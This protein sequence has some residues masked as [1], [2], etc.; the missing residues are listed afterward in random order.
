MKHNELR[1]DPPKW[2][3]RYWVYYVFSAVFLTVVSAIGVLGP[4]YCVGY[5]VYRYLVNELSLA[6]TVFASLLL[7]LTLEVGMCWISATAHTALAGQRFSYLFTEDG[8]TVI[9]PILSIPNRQFTILWSEIEKVTLIYRAD[10]D[11]KPDT[12][13]F[14]KKGT[15][16][17]IYGKLPVL[18]PLYYRQII[19][20]SYSTE[21]DEY[22][23]QN[24]TKT[25]SERTWTY[26]KMYY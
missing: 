16:K 9:R 10:E 25:I 22:L 17:N 14:I 21:L 23:K 20:I 15:K 6:R 11:H 26:D 4:L 12:Y 24:Y 2:S 13:V 19:I 18:N 1:I 3:V 5:N 7:L 8:I